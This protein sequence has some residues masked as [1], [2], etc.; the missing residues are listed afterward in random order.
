MTGGPICE[1]T[2]CKETA[3]FR[4]EGTAEYRRMCGIDGTGGPAFVYACFWCAPRGAA[5]TT[6]NT[7]AIEKET[8]K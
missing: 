2:G 3:A 5:R 8:Q 7:V 1:V 6:Y 4:V